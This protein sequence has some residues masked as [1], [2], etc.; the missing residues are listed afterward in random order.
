MQVIRRKL[1]E[2]HVIADQ[3]KRKNMIRAQF[4]QIESENGWIIPNDETLL[5]EVTSLVEYPT[6]FSGNTTANI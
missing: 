1:A 5:E 2:Q 4:Q 3:D 6:A